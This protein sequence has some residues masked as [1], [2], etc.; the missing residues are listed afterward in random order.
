MYFFTADEHYGHSKIRE[1]CGRS[2][3]SIEE[4]DNEIIKRH[5]EVVTDNDIVIH[6]GDFTLKK[7][8]QET[9]KYIKQLNGLLKIFLIGSHDSWIKGTNSHS[10][11]WEQ[12]IEDRYVVVC[13]YAM[14]VWPRS[15]Y[16]SWQLF[17]HS[18]GRVQPEGKQWD[19]GVDVNNFY[20][21][22]FDQ[23]KEIMKKRPDNF[24]LVKENII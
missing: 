8:C 11:I 4:M 5:N 2:F 15:H 6:A 12:M 21:I 19:V 22:S 13:H 18:H 1:Y 20:P 9:L 16:N 23:L 7:S 24:N 3:S 10:Y 14:R 17:G